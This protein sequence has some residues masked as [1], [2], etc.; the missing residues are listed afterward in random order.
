MEKNRAAVR[1]LRVSEM[2][3]S[4]F[5]VEEQVSE[6]AGWVGG[7]GGGEPFGVNYAWR[8]VRGFSSESDAVEYAR[9]MKTLPRVVWEG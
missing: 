8:L 1:R 5:Y 3:P 9:H 4:V 2:E 7:K 6:P